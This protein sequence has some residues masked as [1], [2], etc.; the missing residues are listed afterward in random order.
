[1]INKS[2]EQLEEEARNLLIQQIMQRTDLDDEQ[3]KVEASNK[4]K[5]LTKKQ[6]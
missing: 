1:M 5:E 6:I 4:L 2:S 3:K